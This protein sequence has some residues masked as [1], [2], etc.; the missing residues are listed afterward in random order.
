MQD[1]QE[2]AQAAAAVARLVPP[3]T[4]ADGAQPRGGSASAASG[5]TAGLTRLRSA[6]SSSADLAAAP[7][8]SPSARQGE[9]AKS[10]GR[11]GAGRTQQDEDVQ[12]LEKAVEAA[13]IDALTFDVSSDEGAGGMERAPERARQRGERG[14]KARSRAS[15]SARKE[16]AAQEGQ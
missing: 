8:S 14:G 10:D 3:S 12:S 16:R 7:P 6:L 4:P 5:L 15:G 13:G 9:G 2:L 1:E 11:R